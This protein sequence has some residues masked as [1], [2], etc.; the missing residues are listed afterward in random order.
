LAEL[1]YTFYK[2]ETDLLVSL[3][4]LVRVWLP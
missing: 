4:E 1:M 3:E 2:E